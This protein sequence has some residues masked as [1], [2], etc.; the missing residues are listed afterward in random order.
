MKILAVAAFL[1][2]LGFALRAVISDR[3]LVPGGWPLGSHW[4][5]WNKFA[6][7]FFLVAGV[8]VGLIG[9]VRRVAKVMT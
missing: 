8:L 3:Y 2:A 4:Y 5:H 1:V 6:F 7:W 9:L